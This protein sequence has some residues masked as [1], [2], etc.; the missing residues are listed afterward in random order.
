MN[1]LSPSSYSANPATP[2]RRQTPSTRVPLSDQSLIKT[3]DNSF[4]PTNTV[5]RRRPRGPNVKPKLQNHRIIISNCENDP[6]GPSDPISTPPPPSNPLRSSSSSTPATPITLSSS[7]LIFETPDQPPPKKQ[8]VSHTQSP[9]MAQFLPMPAHQHRAT[10][11]KPPETDCET[12]ERGL[13]SDLPHQNSPSQSPM[14]TSNHNNSVPSPYDHTNKRS[15]PLEIRLHRISAYSRSVGLPFPLYTYQMLCP[16]TTEEK[17]SW[18]DHGE[19]QRCFKSRAGLVSAFVCGMCN[20]TVSSWLDRLARHPYGRVHKD[21]ADMFLLEHPYQEIKPVRPAITSFSA[22]MVQ[23]ELISQARVAVQPSLGL[24]VH[25]PT[26]RRPTKQHV[27]VIDWKNLTSQTHQAVTNIHKRCQ[28]LLWGLLTKVATPEQGKRGD[29]A[30]A[31]RPVEAVVSTAI[32]KLT[33]SRSPHARLGPMLEGL[34]NMV[35]LVS[36]DRF[37]YDSHVGNTPAYNTVASGL[38]GLGQQ[39]AR[40]VV[41][42]CWDPGY[43]F[44]IVI[45]N[46]QNYI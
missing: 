10:K 44:W 36:F 20:I 5:K 45:D 22:Q 38:Y 46:I 7:S 26:K 25:I 18:D 16:P 41:Y 2:S 30:R 8:K 34:F 15:L 9:H 31:Y 3:V 35:S 23:R 4:N 1:F 40:Q 33:F 24:H 11:R 32:S 13:S 17:A 42:L 12:A 19:A 43:W 6:S 29:K 21:S 14:P 39:A 27:A 37:R 28:N